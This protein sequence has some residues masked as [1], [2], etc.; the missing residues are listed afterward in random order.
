MRRKLTSMSHTKTTSMSTHIIVA[1]THKTE[2]AR[3]GVQRGFE[4]TMTSVP[5]SS[6][7]TAFRTGWWSARL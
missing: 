2:E 7:L 6:S 4:T 5:W 1:T 3:S